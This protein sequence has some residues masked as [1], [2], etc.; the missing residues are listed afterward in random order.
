MQNSNNILIAKVS[1]CISGVL[2]LFTV[3]F[4]IMATSLGYQFIEIEAVW[5]CLWIIT[6]IFV[7]LLAVLASGLGVEGII[8]AAVIV[9][10]LTNLPATFK[11]LGVVFGALFSLLKRLF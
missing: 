10:C 8:W 1:I 6:A 4:P 9:L 2:L 5:I 3:F 7:I 11:I